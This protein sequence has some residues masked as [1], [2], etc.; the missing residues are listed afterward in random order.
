MDRRLSLA[1]TWTLTDGDAISVPAALPGDNYSAL[2]DAGVIPDPYE[3]DN[4]HHVQWVRERTW[5][6]ARDVELS[7]EWA[8]LPEATLRFQAVDTF[9]EIR[10]NGTLLGPEN[11]SAMQTVIRSVGG[12]LKAGTNR[13]EITLRPPH[14]EAQRLAAAE[15]LPIAAPVSDNNRIPA[16]NFVRKT[17]CHA[18]WDWAPCLLVCGLYG[19]LELLAGPAVPLALRVVR[20]GDDWEISAEGLTLRGWGQTGP[21]LRVPDTAIERWWPAG[22]GAQPL[23]PVEIETPQG[24]A[25]R[26]IGFRELRWVRE[27]DAAGESFALEVN[28]RRIFCKG[29]NWVPPSA[30][31]SDGGE[32]RWRPLLESAVAAN[33]NMLRIW[34]GGL[35]ESDRFYEACDELGI[36]LWHDCMF[37][38]MHYPSDAAFLGQIG[39]EIRT[40]IAR[41][42]HHPAIALWC[43]D[44]EILGLCAGGDLKAD[45]V[46]AANY[47][48]FAGA[49]R[50]AVTESDP[51]RLFWPSSPCNGP[52]ANPSEC[53]PG[54]WHD[55]TRGDMHFWKVWHGGEGLESYASVR[56]RF[57]SEFGFQSL[58]SN[59]AEWGDN[60]THPG[61][62]HRQK[63]TCTG[64]KNILQMMARYFR[65]PSTFR[66]MIYLSQVQQAMAIDGAVRRWR[67]SAPVCMGTLYWQLNDTWPAVSWSSI[68][69]G[70]RW[71]LLHYAARRFYA[72]RILA[73]WLLPDRRAVRVVLCSDC[74]AEQSI[75][76]DIR[77]HAIDGSCLERMLTEA[78]TNFPIS[79]PEAA[80]VTYALDGE[81]PE[82]LFLRPPKVYDLPR[83]RIRA[84]WADGVLRLTASAPAFWVW[85]DTAAQ[86]PDNG[87]YLAP[88]CPR[89]LR[90]DD[91]PH[92]LK[93]LSLCDS[94][95]PA[96]G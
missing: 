12:L 62:E 13:I 66:Q 17:A 67:A 57:C 36:L 8:A 27:P 44:N 21:T 78:D 38:C 94:Y 22:A 25:T 72:Q 75:R 90:L 3:G 83:A 65:I 69:Y 43:G 35:W 59:A 50:E 34:G 61:V 52:Y 28:G 15:P 88:D 92:D 24:W 5:T 1:G 63:A 4:E 49:V 77:L 89:T 68:E 32:S 30:L 7:P 91:F 51:D 6:F 37:A 95:T 86:L 9:A 84:E 42:R 55:E 18:G 64:N 80:Y 45:P 73:A 76:R 53:A 96:E 31:P 46:L 29:A 14:L 48:R 40:Q 16:M 79:H 10:L 26:R 60:L 11:R 23:Y 93:M 54:S 70:G 71:K 41:L 85:L 47:F 33:M 19:D 39:S 2:R 58:P 82:I 20:A 74:P 87:F 81:P 56:P